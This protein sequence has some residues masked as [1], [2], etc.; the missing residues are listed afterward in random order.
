MQLG[1]PGGTQLDHTT[2]CQIPS[3]MCAH[4]T[5]THKHIP[6]PPLPSHLEGDR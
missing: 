1:P 6:S 5:H 4:T 2:T 3:V